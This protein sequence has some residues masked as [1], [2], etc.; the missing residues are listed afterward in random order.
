MEN[1]HL[2]IAMICLHSSPIGNIGTQDT[3]GMSVY[4]RELSRE[5]GRL[6]HYV[7]IYTRNNVESCSRT[8]TLCERVRIIHLT[9]KDSS[10]LSKYELH[11]LIPEFL[12]SLENFRSQEEICYDLIYSHYWLSGILGEWAR[13]IWKVPHLIMFHTL[14]ALK[15]SCGMGQ[16]ESELRI[17]AEKKLAE[18][19]S[20][21]IMTSN[22]ERNNFMRYYGAA[23]EK[24]D[25]VPCGVHFEIFRPT[26]SRKARLKLGL[27]LEEKI[28][29]YVGRLDPLKGIDRLMKAFTLL[30]SRNS[31]RLI[32]VGENGCPGSALEKLMT[33]LGIRKSVSFFERVN[34]TLLPLYYSAADVLAVPSL[35][36]SFG[37]VALESLACG[38]P[39]VAT[40]VGSMEKIII[41]GET[42]LVTSDFSVQAL[43]EA[44]NFYVSGKNKTRAETVRSSIAEYT[45]SRSAKGV[46]RFFNDVLSEHPKKRSAEHLFKSPFFLKSYA[47]EKQSG[48]IGH[49]STPG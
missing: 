33:D 37:L 28:I 26:E 25:L 2:K 10:H 35:Y 18:L 12:S 17:S 11:P 13:E 32:I 46:L 49:K 34:H 40:P 19:S 22:R 7:D 47:Y 4:V 16:Q 38:T 23:L 3:G 20:G 21:I 29:L 36:E 6:G 8:I 42:G 14:G 30:S 9:V 48:H 44:L 31:V 24:T 41:K 27:A 5:L 15:N 39:V 1:N 45:W 43:A